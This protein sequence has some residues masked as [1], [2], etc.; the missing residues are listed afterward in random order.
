MAKKDKII[1]GSHSTRIEHADGTITFT[2]DW[3][4]LERDVRE[5]IASYESSKTLTKES[6]SKL[7]KQELEDIGKKYFG[8]DIDR[9]KKKNDLVEE[10]LQA[11]SL[12]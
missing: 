1:K 7:N 8:I 11:Q 3:A 6:L 2:T 5:A 4:A 9:R 10:L 12:N